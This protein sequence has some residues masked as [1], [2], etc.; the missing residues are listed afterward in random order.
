MRLWG[1]FLLAVWAACMGAEEELTIAPRLPTAEEKEAG[2]RAFRGFVQGLNET[3]PDKFETATRGIAASGNERA[4]DCLQRIYPQVDGVRRRLVLQALGVLKRPALKDSLFALSLSEPYL[5]LRRAAA[6]ALVATL[7]RSETA[8]LYLDLLSGPVAQPS[9]VRQRAMQLLAHVGGKGTAE[10]LRGLLKD[11]DPNVA[12]EACDALAVLR[13]LGGVQPLLEVLEGRHPEKAPAAREALARIVGRDHGNNLVKWQQELQAL[14]AQPARGSKDPAGYDLGAD[15]VPDYGQP[16]DVPLAE[17]PVDFVVVYDTTGSLGRIWASVS[18]HLDAVLG[19]MAERCYSLRLGTVRYRSND[20]D[21]SKYTIDPLPLT[22]DLQKARDHIQDATFGGGSGGLHLGLLHAIGQFQWRASARKMVLVVGDVTPVE[23]GLER[24]L[25]T[26]YEARVLDRVFCS[27]L[28]VRSLHGDEHR[29]VYGRMAAVGAGRF[30]EYD[31][32]WKRLVDWSAEKPD[33]KTHE[34]PLE[35]LK[36]WM[37]PFVRPASDEPPADRGAFDPKYR[38]AEVPDPLFASAG[39]ALR[40]SLVTD[41]LRICSSLA[42]RS[43]PAS[44]AHWVR[45]FGGAVLSN[46]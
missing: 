35:T 24:C 25:R 26:I 20:A 33:P 3:D 5:G 2:E 31:R 18:V 29:P 43:G 28:Y 6:D 27:T 10:K 12:I 7:G 41:L 11:P 15:Y 9:L 4:A 38:A 30:Y 14:R 1:L 40:C 45:N 34:P 21:R 17:A 19:E 37:T 44:A 42:P 36:K 13:D 32:A 23:D 39:P 8:R 16:Y 22:R 46:A